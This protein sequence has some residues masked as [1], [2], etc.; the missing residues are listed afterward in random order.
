MPLACGTVPRCSGA[1]ALQR[2]IFAQTKVRKLLHVCNDAN[3]RF[4]VTVNNLPIQLMLLANLAN[5]A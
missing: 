1:R 4:K 5:L 3:A 2:G